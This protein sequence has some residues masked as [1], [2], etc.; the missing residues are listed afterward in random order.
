M[1][2]RD[3]EIEQRQ[4]ASGGL[5]DIKDYS[6]RD[7]PRVAPEASAPVLTEEEVQEHERKQQEDDENM[8]RQIAKEKADAEHARR[9]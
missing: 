2:A 3:V 5:G 7:E 8:A 9:K 4:Q 6:P 1:R